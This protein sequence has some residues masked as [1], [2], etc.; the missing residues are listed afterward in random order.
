[1]KKDKSTAWMLLGAG[2]VN[3][4]RDGGKFTVS[5]PSWL[6]EDIESGDFDADRYKP[7][8]TFRKDS[9]LPDE[10][11]MVKKGSRDP[12]AFISLTNTSMQVMKESMR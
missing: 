10:A 3:A 5:L 12:P 6:Y 2:M 1:M 8:F 9:L 4:I 7:N 11:V